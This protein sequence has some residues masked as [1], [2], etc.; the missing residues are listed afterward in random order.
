MMS[1]TKHIVCF[2]GGHSSALVAVE[3]VR[4]FGPENVIL[5][6]HDINPDVENRDIKR[7]KNEVA[8]FLGLSITFANHPQWHLMD[9]FDVARDAS[10]FKV[11]VKNVICTHRLKTEPFQRWLRQNCPSKNC[12]IY[13]G[14]DAQERA[15]IQRRS[16][17][18]A[19]QGFRSDYPLALWPRTIESTREI[20]IEPP[21]TYGMWK[22]ANCTGCIKAGQQHWYT[23]FCTR[24]DI[25][26][27]AKRAEEDI[28]HSIMRAGFL[29]ELE[30]KFAQMKASGVPPGE[31]IH[32]NTFWARAKRHLSVVQ[33]DQKPCECVF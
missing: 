29:E 17:I 26:E 25:W 23:V 14:F 30:P 6:N 19:S 20:G 31:K 10:A 8:A 7:F 13:Y 33:A 28:D 12:V 16:S 21:L 24:P 18:L 3:V 2:S 9:Q 27:R 4:K 22:H 5:L 32:P 11:G 1:K 15:R